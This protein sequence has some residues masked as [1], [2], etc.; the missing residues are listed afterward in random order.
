MYSQI[1]LSK[2]KKKALCNQ[3]GVYNYR[4]KCLEKVINKSYAAITCENVADQLN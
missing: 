2:T 4:K 1:L 3:L